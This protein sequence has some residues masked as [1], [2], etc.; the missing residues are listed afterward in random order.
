MSKKSSSKERRMSSSTVKS[1][2]HIKTKDSL[3]EEVSGIIEHEEEIENQD[4]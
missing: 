4:F 2:K 1:S 3:N